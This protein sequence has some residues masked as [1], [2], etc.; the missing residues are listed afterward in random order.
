MLAQATAGLPVG[1]SGR[2]L[3]GAGAPWYESWLDHPEH[4][5]PYWAPLQLHEALERTQIPV[6]L[7]SGWQDLFLEQTIAQYQ[8]LHARGVPVAATIGPWT[9]TQMTTKGVPTVLR[10]SLGW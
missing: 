5:D 3:L 8:R 2:A 10:E 6:L 4:D 1:G 7:L 9:H